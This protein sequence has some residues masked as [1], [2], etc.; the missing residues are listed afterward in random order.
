M[1]LLTKIY[2]DNGSNFSSLN[3]I[4]LKH[5]KTSEIKELLLEMDMDWDFMPAH[6]PWSGGVFEAMVKI[7][8]RIFAKLF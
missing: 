6:S 7:F 8:K 2:S 3:G 1:E 4:L 5:R